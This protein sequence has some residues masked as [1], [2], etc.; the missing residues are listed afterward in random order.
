MK[1]KKK[2]LKKEGKCTDMPEDESD[3]VNSIFNKSFRKL[4]HFL[5][6]LCLLE[7]DNDNEYR[8]QMYLP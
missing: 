2:Q 7:T 4:V 3:K 6:Q 5:F 1:T 8:S